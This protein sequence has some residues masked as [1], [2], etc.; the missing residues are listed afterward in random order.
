MGK[1]NNYIYGILIL[2]ILFLLTYIFIK[3][4]INND[5]IKSLKAENKS[6]IERISSAESMINIQ[7]NEIEKY[8]FNMA[9]SKKEY[10][11]NIKIINEKYKK[12]KAD[13]KLMEKLSCEKILNEINENQRRFIY[14]R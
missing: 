9:K 5:L 13:Y 6:L 4:S 2:I 1:I 7:N 8:A 12:L 3:N 14:E 10:K 11:E